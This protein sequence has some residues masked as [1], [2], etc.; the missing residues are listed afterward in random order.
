MI[1]ERPVIGDRL[2]AGEEESGGPAFKSYGA[3]V[4]ARASEEPAFACYGAAV[5]AGAKTGEAVGGDVVRGS[6]RRG[7]LGHAVAS[8]GAGGGRIVRYR[9]GVV[10][11]LRG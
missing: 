1:G 8:L 10:D 9:D 6:F 11:H 4:F 2:R 5:F 7:L 3:A